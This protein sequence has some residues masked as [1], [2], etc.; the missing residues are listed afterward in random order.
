METWKDIPTFEDRYQISTFGRVRNKKTSY[1]LK[2][3]SKGTPCVSFVINNHTNVFEIQYLM[4]VTWL[5]WDIYDTFH[6]VIIHKDE[7]FKNNSLSNLEIEDSSSLQNEVWKDT[8]VF[9]S[10][11]EVSSLGRVRRKK[12]VITCNRKD[13]NKHFHKYVQ[14]KLIKQLDKDGYLEVGL[15][16]N[17]KS[18]YVFV[19]T[20]VATA[21]IQN[22]N[23]FKQINHI[24]GN[25]QN[26]VPSN[27]EWCS[28]E[29]NIHH[30]IKTGLRKSPAKGVF[31][32]PVSVKCCK[33]GKIFSSMQECAEFYD[34]SY[35]YLAERVRLG[36]PVHG[37]MFER[38]N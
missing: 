27:L 5:G 32:H 19:H 37:I 34:I 18:K 15:S 21:F 35:S 24:D 9:P 6:P 1:I 10:T 16:E 20:L 2:S 4:C 25:K 12:K 30:A 8:F 29:Y 33:D 14:Q 17:Y 31:R 22:P 26:N 36:K 23:N 28:S 7:D 13:T 3:N 11:Y 38:L